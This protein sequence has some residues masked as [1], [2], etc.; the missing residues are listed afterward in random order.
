MVQSSYT[1]SRFREQMAPLNPWEDLEDRVGAVD[2]PHR[3]TLASVAELPF[4]PGHKWGS[5]WNPAVAAI[6]G[7]WQFSAKYEWQSGSPLVFNQNTYFDPGCGDPRDLTSQWGKNAS[8]QVY[9]VDVPIFDTTCFYTLQ[10][11]AV[12]QRGRAESS[13]SRPPKSGWGSP[14]SARFRRRCRMCGSWRIT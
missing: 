13:R 4:G 10:R 6:L 1:W 8:G 14:T 5:D 11:P 9:G 2:R 7:G 3:I 12:P